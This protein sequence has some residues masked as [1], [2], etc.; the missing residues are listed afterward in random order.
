MKKEFVALVSSL[1]ELPEGKET[2]LLIRE[3]TPGKQKY[4]GHNVKAILASSPDKLPEGDILWLRFWN[5]RLYP[6]PWVIRILEEL[7]EFLPG[8]PQEEMIKGG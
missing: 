6:H 5:G 2:G 3:L 7:G 8:Y 4:D 1:E